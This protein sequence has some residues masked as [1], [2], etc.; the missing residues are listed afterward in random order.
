MDNASLTLV[1]CWDP[2]AVVLAP[3]GTIFSL[4]VFVKAL[5]GIVLVAVLMFQLLPD[6]RNLN[7]VSCIEH[8]FPRTAHS[9]TVI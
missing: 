2:T 5:A 6:L 1:S 9:D 4:P 3:T 8:C 7:G